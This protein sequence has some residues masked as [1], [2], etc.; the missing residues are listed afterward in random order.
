MPLDPTTAETDPE[1]AYYQA[2]EELFVARRGEHLLLSNADWFLMNRWRKAGVPLRIVLRGI[3]D[4]FDARAQSWARRHKIARLA[5]CEKDVAWAYERWHRA[6]A[7][8]Q[9]EGARVSELLESLAEACANAALPPGAAAAFRDRLVSRLREA[10]TAG[11]PDSLEAWLRSEEEELLRLLRLQAGEAALAAT[12]SDVE[13]E[14]SPYRGRMPARVYQQVC[15]ESQA[16][17]LL[18][19]FGLPRL[20]LLQIG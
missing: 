14:L 5:A 7:I 19:K 6:L 13:R 11:A 17:R 4:A 3:G 12:A 1:V 20:S 8:G 10:S 16:R 2:I 18:E 9:A 15:L